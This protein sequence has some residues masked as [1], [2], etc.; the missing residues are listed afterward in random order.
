MTRI[1]PSPHDPVVRWRRR[2]VAAL[3]AAAWLASA[4]AGSPLS[5]GRGAEEPLSDE[6]IEALGPV[7]ID[8]DGESIRVSELP[9]SP[10]TVERRRQMVQQY[11]RQRLMAREAERRAIDQRPDVAIKLAEVRRAARFQEEAILGRSL[12]FRT[13]QSL[14]P[15]E[16]DLMA[17]YQA[18]PDDYRGS[19]ISGR[20]WAQPD[21]ETAS[22]VAAAGGEPPADAEAVRFWRRSAPP[23]V[24]R[25]LAENPTSGLHIAFEDDL[26]WW[27][28]KI[29]A[30]ETHVRRPFELVRRRVESDW[31]RAETDRRMTEL[32]NQL[33]EEHSVTIHEEVVE[34]DSLWP[35]RS[36][37]PPRRPERS[38]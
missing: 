27:V 1:G 29:D 32:A 15:A 10:K 20:R 18:H 8:V 33:M 25:T 21:A 17:W 22:A 11:A 26:G 37:P 23:V 7:V 34:D 12:W 35:E 6:L 19:R 24:K 5:G 16:V 4:C 31:R 13:F 14:E 30:I 38:P 2:A 36:S 28:V 3:G 9:R